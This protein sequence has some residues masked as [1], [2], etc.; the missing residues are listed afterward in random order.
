MGKSILFGVKVLDE[1]FDWEL[2]EFSVRDLDGAPKG[3]LVGSPRSKHNNID[4]FKSPPS[5]R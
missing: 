3:E 4:S 2:V 1:V 5:T